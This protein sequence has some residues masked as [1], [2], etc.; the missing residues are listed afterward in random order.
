[1]IAIELSPRQ[2]IPFPTTRTGSQ[3]AEEAMIRNTKITR[4]CPFP[5]YKG[6]IAKDEPMRRVIVWVRRNQ[7][8]VNTLAFINVE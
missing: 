5:L 4:L 1:M 3:I 2:R 7:L 6:N 8:T